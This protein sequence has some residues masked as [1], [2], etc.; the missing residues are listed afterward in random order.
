MSTKIYLVSNIDNDPNKIYIGK[1]KKCRKNDHKRK[2]GQQIE[3][4]IINEVNSEVKK[5]WTPIESYWIEQFKVWGFN[6]INKNLGGGGPSHRT[7]ESISNQIER[8]LGSKQS[9]ET[10]KKRS[11]STKG[12]P[13]PLDF[14][15]KLKN[16]KYSQE[17]LDKM[18]LAK[19]GKPSNRKGK[20]ISEEHKQAISQ[21]LKGRVS[22]N[23]KL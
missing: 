21:S 19:L 9:I 11:E 4:T 15:K 1:T 17:T 14:S 10:C 13:K 12:K 3:Y 23:K 22:P 20:T 6:V 7:K 8:M 16:R 2:Y 5:E 18:R